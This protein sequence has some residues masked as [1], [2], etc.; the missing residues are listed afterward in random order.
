[1][2]AQ[3]PIDTTSAI[4]PMAGFEPAT[5]INGQESVY[6]VVLNVMEQAIEWP[7]SIPLP[8]GCTVRR[9]AS[10]QFLQSMGGT[11]VPRTTFL[12]HVRPETTGTFTLPAYTVRARG[13]T[14]QIPAA[15]LRVVP[16]GSTPVE[17]EPR[18][19]LSAGG[20]EFY[21]GQDIELKVILPGRSDGRIQTLSQVEVLGEGLIVDRN[22]RSQRVETAIVNG[23]AR[24]N[25]I[26]NALV[27]A[28]RPG[29]IDVIAQG[30]TV[31]NQRQGQLII[32]GPGIL[33]AGAANYKLVDSDPLPLT[34]LPLPRPPDGSGF[35]GAIGLFTMDPPRLSTNHVQAGDLVTLSLTIRGLGNLQR[36]LPPEIELQPEWQ[37]F[38]PRKDNAL[39]AIVRQRGFVTFEYQLIPLDDAIE[40]TPPIPFCYFNPRS[41]RYMDL[42]VAPIPITVDPSSASLLPAPGHP[43]LV[44]ARS[45]LRELLAKP[46]EP[47]ALADPLDTPGR[48]V[49][50]LTPAHGQ[51]WFAGVQLLPAAL[52]GGLWFRDRRRRFF[53]EHPELLVRRRARRAIQRHARGARRAARSSDAREFL[54]QAIRGFQEACAPAAPGEPRALVCDDILRALPEALRQDLTQDVITRVFTAANEWRFGDVQPDQGA[55]LNLARDVDLQLG[56]LRRRL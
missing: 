31:V 25:F 26:H 53:E 3:P 5:I 13:E 47:T 50:N 51:L 30:H 55:L 8:E 56:E 28:M 20:T 10:G 17:I 11:I 45:F 41:R 32:S 43:S 42:S 19:E 18:I 27:T 22:F 52:L 37:V 7:E 9:G 33:P 16:P 2:V 34:I 1:M 12:Y 46:D 39:P 35:T 49:G 29:R 40:A 48:A 15:A 14:V 23:V 4:T 36:V 21:V 24:P 54:I 44:E 6:R 38:Q